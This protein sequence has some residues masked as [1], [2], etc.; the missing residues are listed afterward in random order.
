MSE[1]RDRED[2]WRH[3]LALQAA[4]DAADRHIAQLQKEIERLTKLV[5]RIDHAIG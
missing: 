1:L 5:G 4:K 3:T 2:E